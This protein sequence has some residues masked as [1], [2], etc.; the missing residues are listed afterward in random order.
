MSLLIFAWLLGIAVAVGVFGAQ[1]RAYRKADVQP[2]TLGSAIWLGSGQIVILFGALMMSF[3]ASD[4]AGE[5]GLPTWL[6]VAINHAANLGACVGCA[7]AALRGTVPRR[8]PMLLAIAGIAIAVPTFTYGAFVPVTIGALFVF[9]AFAGHAVFSAHTRVLAG[10]SEE[11]R[12]EAMGL[13]LSFCLLGGVALVGVPL[14]GG[15]RYGLGAIA[16][17]Q[18]LLAAAYRKWKDAPQATPAEWQ[19]LRTVV[20]QARAH[21]RLIAGVAANFWGWVALYTIPSLAGASSDTVVILAVV[22]QLIAAALTPWAG[23]RA[24]RNRRR[25]GLEAAFALSLALLGVAVA[26]TWP[27]LAVPLL[28][29]S[30]G[31]WLCGALFAVGEY[32]GNVGQGVLEAELSLAGGDG[33]REQL[34]GLTLRFLTVGVGNIALAGLSG[35]LAGVFAGS[36]VGVV[37]GAVCAVAVLGGLARPLS[38]LR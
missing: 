10:V 22:G 37:L 12:G 34:V 38:K 3:G 1:V 15:W 7:V 31:W 29:S 14:L 4:I 26:P 9:G 2:I 11:H 25:V 27:L 19:G 20:R 17:V 28:G 32:G 13:I 24:D 33:V 6:V 16:V 36:T 5:F 21:R 35:A 18:V 23:R 30:L 8:M